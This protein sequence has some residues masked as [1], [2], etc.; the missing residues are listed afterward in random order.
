[1]GYPIGLPADHLLLRSWP[2][3]L[4]VIGV[5]PAILRHGE[6]PSEIAQGSEP[7]RAPIDVPR[8][9]VDSCLQLLGKVNRRA[10]RYVRMRSV[11]RRAPV[12]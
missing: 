4:K 10:R 2:A 7:A 8:G 1:V 11:G 3:G 9:L 12:Q 6:L 5:E